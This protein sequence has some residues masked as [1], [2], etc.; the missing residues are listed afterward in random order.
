MSPE[1]LAETHHIVLTK[2][3]V[4]LTDTLADTDRNLSSAWLESR[5]RLFVDGPLR[6]MRVQQRQPHQW[7]L[8]LDTR[9]PTKQLDA[10]REAVGDDAELVLIAGRLTDAHIAQEVLARLPEGTRQLVTTRLDSDDA[11]G[12]CMLRR[13]QELANCH[14]GF[15]NPALGLQVVGDA[16]LLRYDRSGAFMSFVE[17]VEPSATVRTVFCVEHFRARSVAP[18]HSLP[19]VNYVQVI[20]GGNL[21]NQLDGV[22]VPHRWAC[23]WVGFDPVGVELPTPSPGLGVLTRAAVTHMIVREL[24]SFVSSR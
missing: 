22:P 4:P 21:A 13:V 3:N 7:L 20:H 8:F 23:R 5:L 14:E 9:T 16:V 18:V 12:T 11:L 2:Y 17:R 6:S 24:R 10:L 1:I 15:L 19:G